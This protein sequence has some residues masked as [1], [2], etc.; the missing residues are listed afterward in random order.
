MNKRLLAV[1]AVFAFFIVGLIGPVFPPA[2]AMHL[3]AIVFGVER[4]ERVVICLEL[5][6]AMFMATQEEASIAAKE[7]VDQYFNRIKGLIYAQKCDAVTA[8]YTPLQ[9]I[10]QWTGNVATSRGVIQKALFSLIRSESNG[11]TVYVLT[12]D[13]APKPNSSGT[14]RD[15]KKS[16]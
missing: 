12:P 3:G 7:S 10:Y 8:I 9:T 11:I 16:L 1:S 6:D 4:M 5:G 2:E 15:P 14:N 13:E